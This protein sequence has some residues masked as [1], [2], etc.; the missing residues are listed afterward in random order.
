MNISFYS[1]NDTMTGSI[2]PFRHP[3]CGWLLGGDLC[4]FNG[5]DCDQDD[6][7]HQT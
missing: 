4:E 1:A 7:R 6:S 2:S 3:V 5:Y